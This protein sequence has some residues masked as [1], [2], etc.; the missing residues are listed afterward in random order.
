MTKRKTVPAAPLPPPMPIHQTMKFDHDLRKVQATNTPTRLTL[1]KAVY[2]SK[3]VTP[4]IL[5]ALTGIPKARLLKLANSVGQ[6]EPWLDEAVTLARVLNTGGI[7]PLIV[8][9]NLTDCPMGFHL[10]A[11]VD[12]MRAGLRLPLSLACRLA[13]RFGLDDPIDLVVS[14]RMM[15]IWSV[16]EASER[17]PEAVGWC[18]WCAADILAGA[19]HLPTCLPNNL[20]GP[21]DVVD[22]RTLG[23][24]PRPTGTNHTRRGFSKIAYGVAPLRKSLGLTQPRMAEQVGMASNYLA[25]IE[26][27]NTPLTL[28]YA[29]RLA[30]AFNVTVESLYGSPPP[31]AKPVTV[32]NA[33]ARGQEPPVQTTVPPAPPL[34]S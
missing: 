2:Q 13:V 3:S 34:P 33:K 15:Q 5:S 4:A 1:L 14:E 24:I 31:V 30:A 8:S 12:A 27:G 26:Q 32:S 28:R 10:D 11:D 7:V 18:P 20:W 16:L 6:E 23:Y 21:R 19:A 17:N 29:E 9:G 22:A 25:R